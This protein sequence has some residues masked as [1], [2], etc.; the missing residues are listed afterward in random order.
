MKK[1]KPASPASRMLDLNAFVLKKKEDRYE[2]MKAILN[3]VYQGKRDIDEN[4]IAKCLQLV[5]NPTN[6]AILLPDNLKASREDMKL[7]FAFDENK[8]KG[9]KPIVFATWLFVLALIGT[10]YAAYAYYT[11]DARN[12]EK[13]MNQDIYGDG[14]RVLNVT[15]SDHC[16][17]NINVDEEGTGKP[18]YNI[19]Y[20]G[21]RKAVFNIKGPNGQ[22]FNPINQLDENGK[23]I[24]NCDV[25]GDGW[26]DLNVDL[27]GDGKC[28]L[29]CDT[30]GDGIADLNIDLDGDGICDL[31]CDTNGDGKCD[32]KCTEPWPQWNI[33]IDGDGICDINCD[34]VNTGKCQY[35]CVPNVPGYTDS[36]ETCRINCPSKDK[37]QYNCDLDGDNKCDWNCYA[38]GKKPSDGP[39]YC[40]KNCDFTGDGK[41]DLNC[42]PNDTGKCQYNCDTTGNGKCNLNCYKPGKKPSDGPQNCLSNC[43]FDGDGVCDLNCDPN[44]NGKCQYNCDTTGNGICNKNCYRPGKK[45][46]DGPQNCYLNCDY[47]GNGICDLNCDPN[48]TGKCEYNCDST[49]SGTCDWNCYS[50]GTKPSDGEQYCYL[51]C[52]DGTGNCKSRCTAF[53]T[54]TS[55]M[56]T[57]TT[58]AVT[59]TTTAKPG[60]T[61]TGTSGM[62][63][64]SAILF[65]NYG[66]GGPVY[67]TN[68]VPCDQPGVGVCS[69][70]KTFSVENMSN[71]PL[72]YSLRWVIT[73]N[74]FTTTNLK[75]N[76]LGTNGGYNNATYRTMPK[77]TDT[78]ATKTIATNITIPARVTQS[79]SVEVIIQGTGAA[80]NAD[81]GKSFTGYVEIVV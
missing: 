75:Y 35:G 23:C 40:L 20:L 76:T 11:S 7:Y 78:A 32:Y 39:Q 36:K 57:T 81:Q 58:K 38:P 22:I 52:D 74:T 27:T 9:F 18:Q 62:G 56:T 72:T 24:L 4:D 61:T 69:V 25:D 80:Q 68:M 67:A 48:N 44:N 42:D 51:N 16:Q 66:D 15:L 13:F 73:T 10:G 3:S 28:D 45:P 79:Y 21:N 63:G 29:M 1:A 31:R 41:C 2:E 5:N 64:E 54:T 12:C 8:Q 34:P 47:N 55:R 19:D 30:D 33:D 14:L 53:T 17:A 60:V 43:D 70:I 71:Y 26:P 46:S 65:V 6:A 49:G 37:C 59:T 77:V 50:P